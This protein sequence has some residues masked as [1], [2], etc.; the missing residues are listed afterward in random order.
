MNLNKNGIT[1]FTTPAGTLDVNATYICAENGDTLIYDL[2]DIPEQV[3]S[4]L[5]SRKLK[6]C[7]QIFTHA[8]FDHVGA[9]KYFKDK[10]Q[11]PIYLPEDDKG[12]YQQLREQTA[13]FGM[14][15]MEPTEV[16]C[17]FNENSEIV[18]S[19]AALTEFLKSVKILHTPGHS[20]GST[21]FY[22]EWFD[23]PILIAG[24][25]LFYQSIGRTDLPGGDY[26]SIINSITKKLLILP[27]ET[28]IITG[29]GPESTI[30]NEKK[31]NPFLNGSY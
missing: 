3:E 29:H 7:T 23:R 9:A 27:E 14:P 4:I 17:Y 1:L 20:R 12:L 24:D 31:F 26:Q 5:S 19:S 18:S 11:A 16:D 13:Q 8:H 21:C 15:I 6:L 25:T 30:I 28:L 10:Y 2:G 22:T